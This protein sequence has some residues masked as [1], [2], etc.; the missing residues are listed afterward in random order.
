M[1]IQYYV[2]IGI[3]IKEAKLL[4]TILKIL[5]FMFVHIT[6]GWPET[7]IRCKDFDYTRLWPFQE[8]KVE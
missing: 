3:I 6:V 7:L 2:P 8:N 1:L 4:M 5:I